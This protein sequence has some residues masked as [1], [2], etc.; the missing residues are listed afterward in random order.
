VQLENENGEPDA[1]V[2]ENVMEMQ[3]P[4][5]VRKRFTDWGKKL[6]IFSRE[7][8]HEWWNPAEP[9]LSYEEEESPLLDSSIGG[10]KGEA[11]NPSPLSS[12]E[13]SISSSEESYSEESIT[14]VSVR[15]PAPK[16]LLKDDNGR[17]LSI[18]W[19][20]ALTFGLWM[21][22]TMSAIKAPSL[23]DV[24]DLVGACTG[25][26]LAFVLPAVFSFKLKGYSHVSCVILSI[27]GVVGVCGTISSLVKLIRD[28]HQ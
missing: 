14:V 24:L 4:I 23:G 5:P 28:T 13:P 7:D 8:N 18:L 3:P 22:A 26:L 1:A 10:L 19:H 21:L 2:E 15:V 6:W 11:V 20:A 27:G 12:P 25:T 16:W 9:L 17:Q